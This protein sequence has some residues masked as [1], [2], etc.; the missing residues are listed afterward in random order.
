MKYIDAFE[1]HA[2]DTPEEC[3]MAEL[4]VEIGLEKI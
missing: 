2:I 3:R 4:I 1:G